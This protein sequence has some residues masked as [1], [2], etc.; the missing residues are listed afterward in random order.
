[1]I[2]HNA[3]TWFLNNFK[4]AFVALTVGNYIFYNELYDNWLTLAPL[5]ISCALIVLPFAF[6]FEV[7]LLSADEADLLN[8]KYN[9]AFFFFP[10]TYESQNPI[11]SNEAKYKKLERMLHDGRITDEEYHEA[12]KKI[13]FML[14]NFSSLDT[15]VR[16]SQNLNNRLDEKLGSVFQTKNKLVKKTKLKK[17]INKKSKNLLVGFIGKE[18]H[19]IGKIAPG[20]EKAHKTMNSY[21]QSLKGI[22]AHLIKN[23]GLDKLG[24]TKDEKPQM[25]DYSK[26]GEFGTNF[27]INNN[28]QEAK[29]FIPIQEANESK[30]VLVGQFSSFNFYNEKANE[31]K[32]NMSMSSLPEVSKELQTIEERRENNTDLKGYNKQ[33]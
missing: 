10:E 1:M 23:I 20:N 8:Y 9:E 7:N 21:N 31:K 27:P 14:N 11:T 26:V 4:F 5:I 25:E 12:K 16:S 32:E 28:L 3:G 6:Y 22:G 24:N 19:K 18:L 29:N 33:N 13:T 2:S 15:Y 17:N 30:E